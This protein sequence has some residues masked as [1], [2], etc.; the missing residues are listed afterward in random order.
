MPD[1]FFEYVSILQGNVVSIMKRMVVPWQ[2]FRKLSFFN[3]SMAAEKGWGVRGVPPSY[4]F[5]LT[6][7]PIKIDAPHEAPCPHLKMKPLPSEKQT[8][9]LKSESSFQETIPRKNKKKNRNCH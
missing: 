7:L 3:G 5:F 9:L 1:Y 8:P 6:S 4:N 2:Q